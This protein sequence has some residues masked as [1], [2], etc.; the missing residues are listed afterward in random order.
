[1]YGL[2]E[3]ASFNRRSFDR[4]GLG[5]PPQARPPI[6]PMQPLQPPAQ[7]G[8]RAQLPMVGPAGPPPSSPA[9]QNAQGQ[10]FQGRGFAPPGQQPNPPTPLQV[11]QPMPQQLPPIDG[12]MSPMAQIGL[13]LRGLPTP[14]YPVGGF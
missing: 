5:T 12:A 2:S 7:M 10:P 8:S 13:R 11:G 3:R 9:F 4:L 1:M 14:T 6:A